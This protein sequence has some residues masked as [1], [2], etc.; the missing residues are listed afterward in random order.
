M[1]IKAMAA[2]TRNSAGTPVVKTGTEARQGET[3]H[4]VR[5]VLLFGTIA[6]ILLLAAI[7]VYY[8]H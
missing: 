6:A 3:G 8:F 7:A 1:R 2:A 4:G 5:Y